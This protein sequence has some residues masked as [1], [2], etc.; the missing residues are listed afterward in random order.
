M[1][2]SHKFL[3]SLILAK[4]TDRLARDVSAFLGSQILTRQLLRCQRSKPKLLSTEIE[5]KLRKKDVIRMR[6]RR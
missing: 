4:T 1:S 2:E 3:S 6:F 5:R